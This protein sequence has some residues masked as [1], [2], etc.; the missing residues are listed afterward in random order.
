[1]AECWYCFD[2]FLLPKQET[3]RHGAVLIP[4]QTSV[5]QFMCWTHH[6]TLQV[7]HKMG[8]N[9]LD[10][11]WYLWQDKLMHQNESFEGDGWLL[12]FPPSCVLAVGL[13]LIG[14]KCPTLSAINLYLGNR[15]GWQ[16]HWNSKSQAQTGVWLWQVVNQKERNVVRLCLVVTGWLE[17]SN[18]GNSLGHMQCR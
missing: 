7:W 12:H 4:L 13:I 15:P 2:T 1:M 8:Q 3:L 9:V 18:N 10:T 16:I 6:L 5:K 17:V 11:F 14:Q